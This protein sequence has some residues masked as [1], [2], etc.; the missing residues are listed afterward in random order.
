MADIGL[1]AKDNPCLGIGTKA[2]AGT[3]KVRERY[4]SN[5]EIVA[6]LARLRRARL[7]KRQLSSSCF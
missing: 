2:L 4:L 6:F 1:K 3:S 5:E 7:P